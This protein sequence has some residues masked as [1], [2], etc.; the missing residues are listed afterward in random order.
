MNIMCINNLL[1]SDC[2]RFF[3]KA[4]ATA[5]SSLS[6]NYCLRIIA[7]RTIQNAQGPFFN[8]VI[9]LI[10]YSLN[11]KFIIVIKPIVIL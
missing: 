11:T 5:Q 3:W 8:T 10:S 7:E 2:Q 9:M 1:Q 4:I 6:S